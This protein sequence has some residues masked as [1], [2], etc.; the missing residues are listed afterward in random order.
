MKR[1][2]SSICFLE[3]STQIWTQLTGLKIISKIFNVTYITISFVF[4]YF[5]QS[6][7]CTKCSLYPI[8]FSLFHVEAMFSAICDVYMTPLFRRISTCAISFTQ[9]CVAFVRHHCSSLGDIRYT[10]FPLL[11]LLL[12]LSSV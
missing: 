11:N 2:P 3:D 9:T 6:H 5:H 12:L 1:L 7:I 8:H 4:F 10:L